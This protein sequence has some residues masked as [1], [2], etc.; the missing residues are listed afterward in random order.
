MIAHASEQQVPFWT[1]HGLLMR[2]WALAERGEDVRGIADI[3]QGL[4][5]MSAVESALGRTVQF[6]NLAMAKAR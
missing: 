1:A 5:S 3:E 6:A 4:A 2:G